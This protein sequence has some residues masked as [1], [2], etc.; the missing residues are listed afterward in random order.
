MKKRTGRPRTLAE[1]FR[2]TCGWCGKS[3]APNAA[4]FGSG[5]RARPGV[6]LSDKAGQVIE[7]SLIGRAR[8]VLM[9]V[10]SLDSPARQEGY[11]LAFVTYSEVCGQQ[12]SAALEDEIRLGDE[13]GPA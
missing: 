1:R 12:L 6:D 9:A 5:A 4:V 7:L 3:L 11:D 8:T 2:S 10:T 13:S